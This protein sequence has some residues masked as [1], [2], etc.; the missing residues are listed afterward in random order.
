M[1]DP[2]EN[3]KS[4]V[5]NIAE[6]LGLTDEQLGLIIEPDRVLRVQIPVKMDDGSIEVFTGFRS[7]HKNVLGPYKGGIR[8]HPKV[9]ESE[10]KALS[11]WMSWKCAVVD[12]PLGGGK[13]GV[14]VDPKDLSKHELER[15]ARG[16]VKSIYE[17]IGEEKDVPAPDVNTTPEIMSWMIDEYQKLS[18]TKSL[19]TFTGKPVGNGGSKGRTEATGYGGVYVLDELVDLEGLEIEDTSIAIQGFGNVGYYFAE[20]AAKRGYKIVA[21]SDSKG[22]IYS[23]DGIDPEA[24]MEYKQANGQLQ[25]LEGCEKISNEDLL[26]LDVDVLAPAALENVI[27]EQNA[28]GVQAK[29]IIE[30]ANGPVTPEADEILFERGIKNVPDIVANSGGVTVSYYEWLQNREDKYWKKEDVLQKLHDRITHSFENVYDMAEKENIDLRMAAYA[31]AVKSV[32]TK[33]ES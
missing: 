2:F 8:F 24:A 13:G 32:V 3:A 29:Y 9:S 27:T 25:G 1:E 5:K 12:L 11:M 23:E 20:L 33:M 7:Q 17:V 10:V 19:A 6:F 4:Q 18:G 21:L 14:I 31:V 28:E 22:G 30:L 15:L 16:F 26:L